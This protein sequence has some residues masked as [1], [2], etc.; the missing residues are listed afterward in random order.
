MRPLLVKEHPP[1]QPSIDP[2]LLRDKK[3]TR[4]EK[5]II[6]HYGGTFGSLGVTAIIC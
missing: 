2:T 4:K 3:K 6:G 5:H 1:P